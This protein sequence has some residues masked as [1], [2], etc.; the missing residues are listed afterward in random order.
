MGAR[1]IL[2]LEGYGFGFPLTFK[3]RLELNGGNDAPLRDRSG[4]RCIG[5][6]CQQL[7]GAGL[8]RPA[9]SRN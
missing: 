1:N 7:N 8:V 3:Q 2:Y 6:R 4:S 5:Q 9:L